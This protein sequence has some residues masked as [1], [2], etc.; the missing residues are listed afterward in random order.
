VK[1]VQ[2]A[3]LAACSTGRPADENHS[4]GSDMARSFLVAGVPLVLASSWDV[5]SKATT[6]LIRTFYAGIARPEPLSP[7]AAAADAAATLRR[8]EGFAHPYYWAAFAL[9]R[10]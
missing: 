6:E 3:V 1:N 5:N 7:E 8:Q 4:P 2:L 10:R 9:Y